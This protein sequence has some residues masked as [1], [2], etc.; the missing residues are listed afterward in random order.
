MPTPAKTFQNLLAVL[1]DLLPFTDPPGS[2]QRLAKVKA[3]VRGFWGNKCNAPGC[4]KPVLFT[5]VETG[6][7]RCSHELHHVQYVSGRRHLSLGVLKECKSNNP[8][9]QKPW[10]YDVASFNRPELTL[11][12][13]AQCHHGVIHTAWRHSPCWR[14]R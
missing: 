11:F 5:P 10:I 12:V 14:K 1:L 3:A 4:C 7:Q 2:G 6:G 8:E 13:C 9:T